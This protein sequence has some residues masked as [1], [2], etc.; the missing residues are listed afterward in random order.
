MHQGPETPG[1]LKGTT[2]NLGSKSRCPWPSRVIRTGSAHPRF[3][4]G[5]SCDFCLRLSIQNKK[6]HK[7]SFKVRCFWNCFIY[8]K[9]SSSWYT[10]IPRNAEFNILLFLFNLFKDFIE[11]VTIFLLFYAL[12]FGHKG[13]TILAPW[14]RI[15]PTA[16]ALEGEVLTTGLP[17]SI[18]LLEDVLMP[19][20]QC[21]LFI[22]IHMT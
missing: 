14:P 21:H 3:G 11:F 6:T 12:F 19:D 13:C 5:G 10:L 4:N 9:Y 16:S 2:L 17:G 1:T 18:L 8:Q 22:C 15:E 20:I 7:I